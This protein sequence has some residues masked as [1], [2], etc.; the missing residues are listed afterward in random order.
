M[1]RTRLFRPGPKHRSNPLATHR[2]HNTLLTQTEIAT[3]M[4]PLRA[5]FEHIRAGVATQ[6]EFVVLHSAFLIAQEIEAQGVVR[7]L[8]EHI[9]AA[10]QA[11]QAYEARSADGQAWKPSAL[12]FSELDA[13]REMLH[14]HEYQLQQLTA[15]ELHESAR[16]LIARTQSQGGKVYQAENDASQLTPY[17]QQQKRKRA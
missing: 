17:Q 14:L 12:Y 4:A 8:H 16:R 2:H 3:T 13:M 15:S 7:G 1:T 10:L 9:T 11:C 6:D 5:C